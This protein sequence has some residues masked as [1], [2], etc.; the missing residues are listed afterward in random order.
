[1]FFIKNPWR[2]FSIRNETMLLIDRC[3]LNLC[4]CSRNT[5]FSVN[6]IPKHGVY[7]CNCSGLLCTPFRLRY[8]LSYITII[9]SIVQK[10]QLL[11]ILIWWTVITQWV[12][13]KVCLNKI[14]STDL[15]SV[16][17]FILPESL[18]FLNRLSCFNPISVCSLFTD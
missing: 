4:V 8:V 2:F 6:P 10:I 13:Q 17:Y 5:K 7:I 16:L 15:P 18:L 12:P 3:N 11:V 9:I 14:P 1:M